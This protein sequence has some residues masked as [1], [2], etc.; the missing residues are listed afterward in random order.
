M[1]LSPIAATMLATKFGTSSL[2]AGGTDMSQPAK[3][4]HRLGISEASPRY[5]M[6]WAANKYVMLFSEK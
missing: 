3:N 4:P 6:I 5:A 2:D 1:N